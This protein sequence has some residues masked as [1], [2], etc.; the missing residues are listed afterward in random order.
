MG[1]M[2]ELAYAA[3][4]G[5]I[6]EKGVRTFLHKLPTIVGSNPTKPTACCGFLKTMTM[7]NRPT[8]LVMKAKSVYETV[9]WV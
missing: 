8:V 2:A 1:L 3:V 9:S 5:F 6:L 7:V 4:E